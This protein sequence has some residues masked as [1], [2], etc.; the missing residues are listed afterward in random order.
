MS[1]LERDVSPRE[2][3]PCAASP[4]SKEHWLGPSALPQH[5]EL[6]FSSGAFYSCQSSSAH[7]FWDEDRSLNA[8]KHTRTSSAA[9][10]AAEV[11]TGSP[12][13]AVLQAAT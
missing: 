3:G 11:G 13:R 10:A 2:M 4:I 1:N 12:A 6:C 7:M 9:A 8:F 5:Q